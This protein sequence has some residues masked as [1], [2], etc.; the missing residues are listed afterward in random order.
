VLRGEPGIGKTALLKYLLEHAAGCRILRAAGIESEMELSYAGLHQLCVSLLTGLDDLPEPQHDALAT[1]FGLRGGA[2]PNR[3]L[4]G[5]ATLS[6][7][8]DASGDQPLVCIVDDAQWFDRASIQTLEFVAR[9]LL[10]ESILLV[11]AV[12]EPS[13]GEV[14]VGLPEL[15][16][17]RLSDSDSRTLL[18]S[19][20]AGR[21]DEQVR[22]RIVA[23]TCGNPLALLELPRGLTT[24][25]I[26]GGF[27]RPDARPLSSQLEHG[28]IRRV[29]ALP[30]ETQRL[31]LT[32]AAEPVGDV[33]LLRH[34]AGR[35]EIAM[36][37]AAAQA[38]ASGLVTI[39]THV[40]FR[41][42][43]VRSAVYRTAGPDERRAV[44]KALADATDARIDPDRRAWHR[45]R[46][47][48]GP[49]ETVAVELERS[50]DRARARGGLAA[51]A[52]FLHRAAELSPDPARRGA[53]ALAAA[54][55]SYVAGAYRAALELLDAA[56]LSPLDE[57]DAA[58]LALLRGQLTFYTKGARAGVPL[59][60]EAA[61]RLDPLDA[62][63]ARV[64]Y[65]DACFAALS[66]GQ[67]L[68]EV[69]EAILA[70]PPP[71]EPTRDVLLLQGLARLL[72][73]GYAA[74]TPILLRTL[75]AFRTA[76][77]STDEE[78]GW[79][80]L[81]CRVASDVWDFESWS[82][83]SARLVDL[84]RDEG[85]LTVLGSALS[86]RLQ[87][88][89]RAADLAGA[90]TVAAE[91]VAIGEAVGSHFWPRNG[92][93][94]LDPW[95]GRESATHETI[96]AVTHAA[97]AVSGNGRLLANTQWA[98]AVLYNGLGRYEEAAAAASRG[99]ANPEELGSA[100]DSM[101]ELVEAS[102][103]LGRPADAAEAVQ[104]ISEAARATDTD[105]ALGT[106]AHVRALVSDGQASDD[107]YREAIERLGRTGN[108]MALARA[109]L[110]YGEWLRRE[111]RRVEAR[112]QLGLAHETLS[113]FGAEAFAERAGRE[114]R[115]TGATVRK[116][117]AAVHEELTSQEAQIA[118]LAADGL[119]NPEIGA[120]LFISPHTVEWHLSKVYSK[121]GITSRRGIAAML[122][123]S[124][125]TS[126]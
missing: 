24:A 34:A 19:V 20:I 39:G 15:T 86:M 16:V 105:W 78:L 119:T 92:S 79:L 64:T 65:R 87:N 11:F 112:S 113:Q 67:L 4:V 9:R 76:E 57:L 62:R 28:F 27:M 63:T 18:D 48:V 42:P 73:E 100:I 108:R 33:M 44:H 117:A 30:A 46:A 51:A 40:R 8:A 88:R 90:E 91:L 54:Q 45:A 55:A 115:A 99:G 109:R 123:Q 52:A 61:K 12:R 97:Q 114:L 36:D 5:L 47:T 98:E 58:K 50:A 116:R 103:R 81:A 96:E 7:L 89:V 3:F 106:M 68:T 14:L 85:A 1:A 56:Q 125:T 43:L 22:E 101:V 94:Y 111:G 95:R 60:I 72:T 110:C 66:G 71:A 13:P 69:G 53:R 122:T 6:L 26:A 82:V 74:G 23:E 83:L 77:F 38:E 59:L 70:A 121:L 75:A 41:H 2:T 102:A 93:L 37:E 35:L 80:Q 49:E 126:A 84:A 21:L 124:A 104:R 118:R 32:A 29:R 17:A 120:R 31:L 107:L 25:E 10:A